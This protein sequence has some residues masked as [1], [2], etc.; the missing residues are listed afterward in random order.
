[1]SRLNLSLACWDYDRTRPLIDGRVK[2]HGIDLTVKVMRPREAFE[3]MLATGEFDVSEMSFANYVSLKGKGDCPLVA[4]PVMLSKMFRHNC[5]YVRADSGIRG[6][7][8]LAGRRVGTMRYTS[9]ALVFTRGLL[10]DEQGLRA[11]DLQWFIGGINK[12]MKSSRPENVPDNM[13][14]TILSETQTL[15]AMLLA[16]EI[17]AIFTQDMPDSFLRGDGRIRRLFSDPKPVEKDYFARTGIFPIM[18][19][20]VI[21]KDIFDA[22]P[23]VATV[24]FDAFSRAK[25]EALSQLYDTDAL[26]L[27]LPFL[28]DHYEETVRCFGADFFSYGLES[29][30]LTIS[31]LC[32]Y[33]FEQGLS[34][35]LVSPDELFVQVEAVK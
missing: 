11:K 18:H 5:I 15:D 26:H 16:G 12:P 23:W 7:K 13:A 2:P 27:S 20:V 24:L 21:R 1:M 34:P 10:L 3:R 29:N 32:R 33:V 17:D 30:R 31:A 14:C 19:I 35:R 28:T 6:F 8:D 22:H 4:I 25:S 9:T